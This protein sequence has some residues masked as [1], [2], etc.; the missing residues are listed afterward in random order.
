MLVNTSCALVC[1]SKPC[2]NNK[3]RDGNVCRAPNGNWACPVGCTSLTTSPWCLNTGT[4]DPCS[5]DGVLKP[6][7]SAGVHRL[8][9]WEVSDWKATLASYS[10]T[11]T[12]P[13][14]IQDQLLR[15]HLFTGTVSSITGVT[16][17]LRDGGNGSPFGLP[18]Q[19]SKNWHRGGS[20]W[21]GEWLSLYAQLRVA[22]NSQITFEI[23]RASA[24][25]GYSHRTGNKLPAV[26]HNQLC[27]VGW[28]NSK[29][30]WDEVS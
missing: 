10:L 21:D 19:I 5:F 16:A 11:V 29:T 23:V 2:G 3:N 22:K 7:L 27:L 12:N 28:G 1:V 6:S 24:Y 4:Q 20:K 25:W 13:S 15:L 17:V 8:R 30:L 9:G 18:V 14:L 26:S